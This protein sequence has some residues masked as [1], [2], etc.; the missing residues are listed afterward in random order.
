ME[1]EAR[2]VYSIIAKEMYQW[3]NKPGK[4]FA[5][6]LREKKADVFHN[7]Y[8]K[9]Y[10]VNQKDESSWLEER[11]GCNTKVYTGSKSPKVTRSWFRCF[12]ETDN[13]RRSYKG[14]WE[15]VERDMP[16]TR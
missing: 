2:Q 6:I 11:T 12:R 14:N 9:L 5:R 15:H 8:D 10:Q 3:G 1:Q 13:S 16:R 4:L 7:Y